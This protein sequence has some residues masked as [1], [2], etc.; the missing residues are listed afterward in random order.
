MCFYQ[1]ALYWLRFVWHNWNIIITQRFNQERIVSFLN[2]L[3]NYYYKITKKISKGIV[4]IRSNKIIHDYF[5]IED[6]INFFVLYY[7]VKEIEAKWIMN[8]PK[9]NL[10]ELTKLIL[11]ILET[12]LLF[13]WQVSDLPWIIISKHLLQSVTFN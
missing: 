3:Y 4:E 6:N 12:T 2:I 11:W 7:K 10:F 13:L 8:I 5:D 1:F 9:Q